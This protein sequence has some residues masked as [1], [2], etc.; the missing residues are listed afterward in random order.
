MVN[1]NI[2]FLEQKCTHVR[3]GVMDQTV[4]SGSGHLGPTFSATELLVALYYGFLNV[5][6]ANP[7][8]P[9]RDRFVLSK[10]HACSAVYPILADLNFFDP[11]HLQTFTRLNSILGD[12]PDFK[13]IP[14]FD[15]SSGSLGH[16]LSVACGMAE[17]LRFQGKQSRVVA[18]VGDGEQ[19]EGQIW[20]AAGYAGFRRLSNLLCICDR[21]QVC[22]DGRTEE[23][24]GVDPMADRWRAFGWHVDEIDGHDLPAI[25]DRLDQFERRRREGGKPTFIVAN[26]VSGKGVDFIEDK[27]VWHLGYLHGE[28]AED[29]RRQILNMY[30]ETSGEPAQ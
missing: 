29:A 6:G 15:F 5:D 12:H 9:D 13:K 23:I 22:V 10:G 28:D 21:N 17:A 25:L 14:G 24:M 2:G 16:G 27:A 11:A 18:M 30:K 7:E 8:W 19:N 3:L 1:S 26:T 20:E 4:V